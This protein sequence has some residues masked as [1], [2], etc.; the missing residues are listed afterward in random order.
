MGLDGL[1]GI[2]NG[3]EMGLHSWSELAEWAVGGSELDGLTGILSG[4][5]LS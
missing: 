5:E 1:T 4:L 2:L 3:L